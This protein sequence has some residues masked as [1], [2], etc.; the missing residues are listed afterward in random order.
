MDAASAKFTSAQADLRQ[1]LFTKVVHDTETQ[2]GQ[3]YFLR[4]G[5]SMQMGMKL[6]PPDASPGAPPAQIVEFRPASSASSIPAPTR[7]TSTPPPA[8]TRPWPKP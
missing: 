1:E 8:R 2:T 4:K 5:G 3:I 7:S 6:L